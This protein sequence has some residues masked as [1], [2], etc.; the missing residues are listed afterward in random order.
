MIVEIA[1]QRCRQHAPRCIGTAESL[2]ILQ[3]SP[4]RR[5]TRALWSSAPAPTPPSPRQHWPTTRFAAARTPLQAQLPARLSPAPGRAAGMMLAA[6]AL[7]A[8]A[9]V[10]PQLRSTDLAAGLVVSEGCRV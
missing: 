5:P 6:T 8:S 3:C 9:A 1:A 7:E 4:G 2:P 10:G